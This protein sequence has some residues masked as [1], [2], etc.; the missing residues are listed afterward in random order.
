MNENFESDNHQPIYFF[1]VV[2][3]EIFLLCSIMFLSNLRTCTR[4]VK[5]RSCKL[6]KRIYK[7]GLTRI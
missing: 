5:N 7:S 4:V 2:I 6:G 1:F 3:F